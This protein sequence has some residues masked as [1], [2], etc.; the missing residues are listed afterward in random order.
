[1]SESDEPILNPLEEAVR[2][3]DATE[4]SY[5]LELGFADN[6]LAHELPGT[7]MGNLNVFYSSLCPGSSYYKIAP[8]G[9]IDGALPISF[10]LKVTLRKN[11]DVPWSSLSDV[12]YTSEISSFPEDTNPI[13]M[14]TC[15]LGDL[16]VRYFKRKNA[17]YVAALNYY[18]TDKGPGD[19]PQEEL[20]VYWPKMKSLHKGQKITK[21]HV[22]ELLGPIRESIKK[23]K[24]HHQTIKR[25]AQQ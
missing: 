5:V 13:A 7:H 16:T 9:W 21:K 10:P 24:K 8:A 25:L 3:N 18:S 15:M 14:K 1:M 22:D 19:I 20:Y 2:I 17:F 11:W 6:H 4:V 12:L 23:A